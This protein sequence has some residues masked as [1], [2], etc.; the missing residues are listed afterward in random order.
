MAFLDV[1]WLIVISF[2]FLAYLMILF[3]VVADLFSDPDSSGLQKALWIIALIFLPLLTSLVYL[4]LRGRRMA[5]RSIAA[6]EQAKQQQDRYIREVAG[7]SPSQQIAQA[8]AL[9]DDGAVTRTEYEALKAKAL[10]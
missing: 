3:R 7:S 4:I 8:K 9:L 2:A 5:E 1:L 6:L 10:A